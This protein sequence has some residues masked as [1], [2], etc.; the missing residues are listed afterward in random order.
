MKC[1]QGGGRNVFYKSTLGSFPARWTRTWLETWTWR[2]ANAAVRSKDLNS[3]FAAIL[4][5]ADA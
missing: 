1:I 5:A 2:R 3:Q 4:E